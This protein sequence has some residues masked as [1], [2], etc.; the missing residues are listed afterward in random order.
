MY[1]HIYNWI[2]DSAKS[3]E[4]ANLQIPKTLVFIYNYI[5]RIMLFTIDYEYGYSNTQFL[6]G[7]FLT[8]KIFIS[9]EQIEQLGLFGQ[10]YSFFSE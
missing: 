4:S 5:G 1:A 10:F 7:L 3:Q 8:L 9:C 6:L 2:R